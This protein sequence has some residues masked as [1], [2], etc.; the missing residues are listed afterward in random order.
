MTPSIFT[1]E[2]DSIIALNRF[3]EFHLCDFQ[4]IPEI[5]N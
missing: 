4:T 2:N 1:T 5:R 3:I